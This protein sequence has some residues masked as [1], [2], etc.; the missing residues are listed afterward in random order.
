MMAGQPCSG[1]ETGE[2]VTRSQ[3]GQNT[4]V[5]GMLTR[6]NA[7]ATTHRH[8]DVLEETVGR[9][10]GALDPLNGRDPGHSTAVQLHGSRGAG[11]KWIIVVSHSVINSELKRESL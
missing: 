1:N 11:Q 2:T 6:S 3:S 10:T 9:G 7:L 5:R 4:R 8:L